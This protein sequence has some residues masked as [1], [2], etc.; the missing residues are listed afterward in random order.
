MLLLL[1]LLGMGELCLAEAWSK[2][3]ASDGS[4]SDWFG[5]SVALDGE[6]LVVGAYLD[7]NAGGSNAGA[8]YVF[9]RDAGSGA[10]SEAQKLLASD[11][12]QYDRFGISVAL[13]GEVLVVGAYE[14]DDA[15]GSNAGAVYVFVR[16]AGSGAWSEA[17][18][19]LASDG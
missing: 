3:L 5:N 9:V 17:Q 11:G 18:K 1:L 8:V 19:L 16:D 15:D 12:S 6:V 13:D 10:W 2:L 4:Q 14:D 7:D